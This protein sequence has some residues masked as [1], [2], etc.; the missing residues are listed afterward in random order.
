MQQQH[1]I[2]LELFLLVIKQ[3]SPHW[4]ACLSGGSLFSNQARCL[5]VYVFQFDP[6][7]PHTRLIMHVSLTMY[8]AG[9]VIII[10]VAYTHALALTSI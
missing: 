8:M 3:L 9:G 2:N 10:V 1:P 7:A 6:P 4:R 5:S